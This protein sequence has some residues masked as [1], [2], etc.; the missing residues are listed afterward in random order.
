MPLGLN[1][2]YGEPRNLVQR[3]MALDSVDR[4]N[5]LEVLQETLLGDWRD[6]TGEYDPG[7][8]WSRSKVQDYETE[9]FT[10]SIWNL[11]RFKGATRLPDG[12]RDWSWTNLTMDAC[13]GAPIHFHRKEIRIYCEHP[14]DEERLARFV[15][16]KPIEGSDRVLG[17]VTDHF[18][19]SYRSKL[20]FDEE[21]RHIPL[22][23]PE[24]PYDRERAKGLLAMVN[25]RKLPCVR[26]EAE[27][28]IG[29]ID[30]FHLSATPPGDLEEFKGLGLIAVYVGALHAPKKDW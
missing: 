2:L 29:S 24:H 30:C 4:L 8:L 25:G 26:I 15:R 13:L 21:V 18:Q 16:P 9:F 10:A 28:Q 11:E 6:G 19:M 23:A 1:D 7:L 5:V 20:K 27:R 14:D 3:V 17:G 22:P 12:H